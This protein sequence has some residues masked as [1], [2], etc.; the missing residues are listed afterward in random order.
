MKINQIN[1]FNSS[2]NFK[3]NLLPPEPN[4]ENKSKFSDTDKNIMIGLAGLAIIGA[5]G[6]G[7]AIL[8]KHNTS[9]AKII[10]KFVKKITSPKKQPDPIL[11]RIKNN[12]DERAVIIYKGLR[13]KAKI[14]SLEQK[15]L[16]GDLKGKSQKAMEHI[17]I[18]R[19]KLQ[20]AANSVI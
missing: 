5:A 17:K 19:Q 1:T 16:N 20:R 7:T 3:S 9:P 11:Q 15:Y 12:R 14:H 13:A 2:I 8:K 6:I 10:N 18:N 4:K